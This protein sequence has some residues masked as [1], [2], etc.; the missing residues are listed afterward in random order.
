MRRR[1]TN[2]GARTSSV[3]NATRTARLRTPDQTGAARLSRSAFRKD[4]NSKS[5][6]AQRGERQGSALPVARGTG[7]VVDSCLQ[8][9]NERRRDFFNDTYLGIAQYRLVIQLDVSRVLWKKEN[10]VTSC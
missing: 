10:G 6:L 1:G 3:L 8:K 7:I 4:A 2:K 9:I 5:L